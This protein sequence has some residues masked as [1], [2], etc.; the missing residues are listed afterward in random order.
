MVD[1]FLKPSLAIEFLG[2]NLMLVV[3]VVPLDLWAQ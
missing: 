3:D 2:A 1:N